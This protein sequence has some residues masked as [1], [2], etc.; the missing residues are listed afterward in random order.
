MNGLAKVCH[1][2]GVLGSGF[3]L[4][5]FVGGQGSVMEK[6][7]Q[8]LIRQVSEVSVKRA[9]SETTLVRLV[10]ND[11]VIDHRTQMFAGA[12]WADRNSNNQTSRDVPAK[13]I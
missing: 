4:S 2:A 3:G 1:K 10:E 13:Q 7:D 12:D 5:R 6:L 9:D 8:F 11:Y